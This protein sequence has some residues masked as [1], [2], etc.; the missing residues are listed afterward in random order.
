MGFNGVAWMIGGGE[1][2]PLHN[3]DLGRMV[4]YLATQGLEGVL[5]PL[6]LRVT[7][8]DTPDHFVNISPGAAVWKSRAPGTFAQSYGNYMSSQEAFELIP[9]I[10]ASARSDLL[11]AR[12]IDNYADPGAPP[13]ADEVVGPYAIFEVLS[14]VSDSCTSFDQVDPSLTAVNLARI[15]WPMNTSAITQAMIKPLQ[16]VINLD[17]Q[18]SDEEQPGDPP[19][20]VEYLWTDIKTGGTSSDTLLESQN[21]FKV[22]PAAAVYTFKV[23][24][25]AT[26]VDISMKV[27]NSSQTIGPVWGE[28]RIML[29]LASP[30]T[31]IYSQLVPF[32]M[33]VAGSF[34]QIAAGGR[35][36]IPAAMRGK[37]ITMSMQARQYVDAPT[38]GTLFGKNTQIE[39]WVHFKKFPT[40]S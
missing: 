15:D 40:L 10:S 12:I 14:N 32:N 25:D 28:T 4:L 11:I 22:W 1:T 23:P 35:V 20:F 17:G 27:L 38:T 29:N 24:I 13:P 7:A 18:R 21:T 2:G 3:A 33:D 9:N 26:Y 39:T 37:L 31:T 19:G 16:S 34:V 30:S 8:L 36:A 5:S 6:D